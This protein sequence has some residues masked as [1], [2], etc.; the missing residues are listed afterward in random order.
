[1][2]QTSSFSRITFLF[3]PYSNMV[4]TSCTPAQLLSNR[5]SSTLTSFNQLGTKNTSLECR[6]ACAQLQNP[7]FIQYYAK[8]ATFIPLSCISQISVE[9]NSNHRI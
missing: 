4:K 8:D 6:P 3:Y 2:V 1:M 9:N 5:F 7:S